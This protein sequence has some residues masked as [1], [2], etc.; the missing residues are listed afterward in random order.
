MMIGTQEGN[1]KH[2]IMLAYI[3]KPTI[4]D[5]LNVSNQRKN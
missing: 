3:E 2:L 4:L 5:C 1:G